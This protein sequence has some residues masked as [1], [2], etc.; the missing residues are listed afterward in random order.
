MLNKIDHIGIA[1][2]SLEKAKEFY[3]KSL[4]LTPSPVEPVPSQM[5][6]TVFFKIGDSKIEFLEGS[7]PES[8]I[9][10]FIEKKGEGIHHICYE[11]DD[12]EETLSELQ[13]SGIQ[14]IDKSP[15]VGAHGK[16]IAFIH[17]KS[18]NGI[19]TELTEKDK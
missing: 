16:K 4:G 13:K 19:L 18:T 7:S 15:R 10:K 2:K 3:E 14:L 5:V 1:V 12:L 9:T 11:V 17:P 6:T 8:P